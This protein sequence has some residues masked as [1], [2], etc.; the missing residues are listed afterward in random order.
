MTY[1]DERHLSDLA[2]HACQRIEAV[3]ATVFP[4]VDEPRQKEELAIRIA[5]HIFGFATAVVENVNNCSYSE[6]VRRLAEEL[7][8]V[9][10]SMKSEAAAIKTKARS[11]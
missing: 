3:L 4:L 2:Q 10:L 5:S 6:A 8:E 1:I 9:T 7:V 11:R